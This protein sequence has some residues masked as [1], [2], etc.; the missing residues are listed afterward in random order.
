MVDGRH[1]KDALA[2]QLER[3]DLQDHRERLNDKDAANEKQKNFLL[4]DD[5]DGAERSAERERADIAHEDFREVRVVPEE[6]ERRAHERSAKYRQFSDSRDV[7]D[8]EIRRPTRVAADIGQHRERARGDDRAADRQA[9][10]T[11]RQIHRIGRSHDNQT[12]ESQKR[13]KRQGPQ[14]LR[15]HEGVNNQV[16][17]QTFEER[18]HQLS[19]VGKVRNKN[20]QRNS[21]HQAYQHLKINFLFRSEPKVSLLRDFRVVVDKTDGCKAD[22]SKEREQ[23]KWIG[24]I[25]PKQ[26]GHGRR[27]NDQHAAHGRCAGFLLVFLRA[28]LADVLPDLQIA[29]PLNQPGAEHEAEKHGRQARIDGSN[30]NVAKNV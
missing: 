23:N 8:L 13:Q 21:H 20:E 11:V 24:Q 6:A 27:Q 28:F 10:E 15:F 29:Q 22:Q 26:C 19:R 3:A 7:L 4:D 17:V 1:A 2:A 14:V 9:V 16:R 12:N 30:S 18:N 5:G 25:R